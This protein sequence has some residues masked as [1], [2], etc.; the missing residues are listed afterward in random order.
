MYL[1]QPFEEYCITR[2]ELLDLLRRHH[3]TAIELEREKEEKQRCGNRSII[4]HHLLR[5]FLLLLTPCYCTTH[6][7]TNSFPFPFL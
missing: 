7:R 2:K 1:D 5:G 3:H 6:T 4:L